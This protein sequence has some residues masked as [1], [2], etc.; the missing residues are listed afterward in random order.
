LIDF[1]SA[2]ITS[3]DCNLNAGLDIR[4]TGDYTLDID[5]LTDL[6][7]L[8]VSHPLNMLLGILT[9]HDENLEL[10]LKFR[11]QL[12][13]GILDLAVEGICIVLQSLLEVELSLIHQN[14]EG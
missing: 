9:M 6:L 3:V 1:K 8:D 5:E 12:H 10:S 14:L 7:R 13:L 2:Y 11:W 4:A